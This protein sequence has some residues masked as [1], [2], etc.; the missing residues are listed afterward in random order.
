MEQVSLADVEPTGDRIDRRALTG[1][2]GTTDLAINQYRVLP[3]EGLPAGLHAHGDQEEVFVVLAGVARFETL[4]REDGE[5]VPS[6]VTVAAGEAIRFSPG[7]FQS[8]RNGGD[9]ELVVLALGAP[10][11]SQDVRVP[12][13]CPDCDRPTLRL[14]TDGDGV[15][16]QCPDC[17]GTFVPAPCPACGSDDLRI[18]LG[19]DRPTVVVC[20]DC[21]AS[22]PEPPLAE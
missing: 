14:D 5:W 7:E 22:F 10:R 2:L 3:G 21:G 12:A 11:D 17:G 16:F 13:T 9:D 18:T 20:G 4:T 6:E 1:P 15:T 19:D 8:G